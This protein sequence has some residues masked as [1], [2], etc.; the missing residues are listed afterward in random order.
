MAKSYSIRTT[1]FVPTD[2]YKRPAMQRKI[3]H[4]LGRIVGR[5]V[6]DV[7]GLVTETAYRAMNK[8]APK[9]VY[10]IAQGR[11]FNS[12]T[13]ALAYAYGASLVLDG[14]HLGNYVME[15]GAIDIVPPPATIRFSQKNHKAYAQLQGRRKHA[16]V[17]RYV[18]IKYS[19]KHGG[20]RSKYRHKKYLRTRYLKPFESYH[21]YHQGLLKRNMSPAANYTPYKK[22]RGSHFERNFYLQVFNVAPYANIVQSMGYNVIEG[23]SIRGRARW[24]KRIVADVT[25]DMIKK[26]IHN[27][28]KDYTKSAPNRQDYGDVFSTKTRRWF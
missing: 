6:N 24:A 7:D 8:L 10:S 13:G 20:P 9:V 23:G 11:G 1:R 16:N 2:A 22:R 14:V 12:Y 28:K 17:S 26:A 4:Q 15:D 3:Q 18:R 5:V 27:Y 21:G 19:Y 25:V